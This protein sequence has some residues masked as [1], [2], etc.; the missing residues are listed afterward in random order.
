M[1]NENTE[2]GFQQPATAPQFT[3][4]QMEAL[5]FSDAQITVLLFTQEDNE[6]ANKLVDKINKGSKS[7]TT[8]NAR[9]KAVKLAEKVLSEAFADAQLPSSENYIPGLMEF[10]TH[11]AKLNTAVFIK[12]DVVHVEA[13]Q[14]RAKRVS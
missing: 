6:A 2:T 7:Q 4:E 3:R 11:V 12:D 10:L 5:G 8:S 1:D 14:P 13:K 9:I